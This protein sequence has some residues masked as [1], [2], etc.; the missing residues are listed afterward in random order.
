MWGRGRARVVIPTIGITTAFIDWR[1]KRTSRTGAVLVVEQC[2][3]V[4]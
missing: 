2:L 3:R 4:V 1:L